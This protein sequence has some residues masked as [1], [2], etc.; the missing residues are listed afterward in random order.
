MGRGGLSCGYMPMA[1]QQVVDHL[2]A[3]KGFLVSIQHRECF[4]DAVRM[5]RQVFERLMPQI[6]CTP[7]QAVEIVEL[8]KGIPWPAADMEGCVQAVARNTSTGPQ[9][10][11]MM[12]RC[13]MQDYSSLSDYFMGSH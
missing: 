1:F 7:S 4:S 13:R 12:G 5:Q 8:L 3:L 9:T 11:A 6:S 2:T 10:V